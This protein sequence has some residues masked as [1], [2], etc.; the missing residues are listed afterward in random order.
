M[1]RVRDWIVAAGVLLLGR[2]RSRRELP[3]PRAIES[4]APSPGWELLAALLLFAAAAAAIAFPF[5]YGFDV[6]SLTQLLGLS[7]GL[8]LLCMAAALIVTA[9]RLIVTEEIEDE[10][11]LEEHPD[12]FVRA[13]P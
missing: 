6:G 8:A 4:R 7:L 11:P 13:L 10:Y 5:L 3:P 1:S 9:K 2:G 12:G